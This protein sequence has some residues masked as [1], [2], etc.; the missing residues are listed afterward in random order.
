M[1]GLGER[2]ADGIDSVISAAG[3]P[4]HV[5]RLGARAEYRFSPSRRG[6][7]RVGE[8]R[9]PRARGV[10]APPRAQPRRADHPLP[11]H[12]PV[13]PATTAADVD[14]HTEVL[15][16]AIRSADVERTASW[17]LDEG[18]PIAPGRTVLKDL[19]GGSRYEVFLVWDER[20]HA[21]C[22][23]KLLRPDQARTSGR[24]RE[25]GEEAELLDGSPT[26]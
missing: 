22:V 21:I 14:R 24:S 6:R 19:G 5:A 10:P 12:V 16:E 7:R 1:T 8:A 3:P 20:M 25:L 18:A 15:A 23:A 26:R 17:D 9:R 4:W 2:L 13:C 11:Q